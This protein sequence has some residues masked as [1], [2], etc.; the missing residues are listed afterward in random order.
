MAKRKRL[1]PAGAFSTG[2]P[3]APAPEV[4]SSMPPIATVSA[5]ASASSALAEVSQALESAR[6]EGRLVQ[7]IP[8]ADIKANHLVRD[9][10]VTDADD[11]QALMTSL[12]ERGQQTPIEVVNLEANEDGNPQYG[13][14]SGW[15]RLKALRTLADSGGS[16]MVALARVITPH[17]E[18]EAYVAMV[19][20]NE[21]R[22]NLSYYERAHVVARAV[23][24]GVYEG[25]KA[26]LNG[27]FGNVSRA[28]RSKIKSFV[29]L[30][31]ALDTHLTFPAA[32][33]E[34]LGLQLSKAL[35]EGKKQALI[36][37]LDSIFDTPEAEQAAL[38]EALSA[39]SPA[40]RQAAA[41]AARNPRPAPKK[42]PRWRGVDIVQEGPGYRLEGPGVSSEFLRALRAWIC[43]TDS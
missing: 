1:S 18:A 10:M 36:E 2:T 42:P 43:N 33:G 22:S 11:M 27:L 15:R 16:A 24:A 5:D 39:P 26:A 20:E 37:A 28:K 21:I 6:T 23:E 41:E 25:R 17:T 12:R 35:A 7:K 8:L 30:V 3:P 40:A 29:D 19:E 34:R 38:R 4:K 32:I 14:V 31:K 13:L 9:R